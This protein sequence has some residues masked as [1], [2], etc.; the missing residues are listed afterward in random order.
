[1]VFRFLYTGFNFF[2]YK[3][4]AQHRKGH[5]IHSPFIFDFIN[6]V[7]LNSK[8]PPYFDEN[9][10]FEKSLKKVSQII[11]KE[12]HGA[13][14]KF[15]K[16]TIV[17]VRHIVKNSTTTWKYRCL[18]AKIISY[19]KP[20]IVLELGTSLGLTTNILANS[21]PNK[22]VTLEGCKEIIN[23]AKENFSKWGNMNISTKNDL[24]DNYLASFTSTQRTFVYI[25]GNHTFKA[26]IEYVN[27]LWNNLPDE[28]IIVIG[29]I[30]WSPDMTKAWYEIS[31]VSENKY[32][33][34]LFHLG[35][36]FK[37][38]NCAGQHFLI[39]Y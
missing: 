8:K 39:R 6:N 5:G 11:K 33:V 15:Q 26:T 1:M 31:K 36:V 34:D 38:R 4:R 14:S 13:G 24:F 9:K 12:D 27:I 21:T 18:L 35:I 20:E 19:Y 17:T 37:H 32:T 25:D 29:D 7:L 10:Q 16:R 28:S 2:K 30:Y 3:I 23:V 22:V